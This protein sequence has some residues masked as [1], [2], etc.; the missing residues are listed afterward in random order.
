MIHGTIWTPLSCVDSLDFLLMV[1]VYFVGMIFAHHLQSP[2][3][4]LNSCLIL[5][6]TEG[7]GIWNHLVCS[8]IKQVL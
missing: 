7:S 2:I 6:P 3:T 5:Q 8:F 4:L 1:C